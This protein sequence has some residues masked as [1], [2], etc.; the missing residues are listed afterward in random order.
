VRLGL[1]LRLGLRRGCT[2]AVQPEEC[3]GRDSHPRRP[4]GQRLYRPPQLLLCHLHVGEMAV[5][6]CCL[7][8]G[9][10]GLRQRF[11]SAFNIQHFR[12]WVEGFEPS[13]PC[14]RGTC[15]NQAELH[16]CRGSMLA[17][18]QVQNTHA[19][20]DGWDRTSDLVLPRHACFRCTTSWRLT[21]LGRHVVT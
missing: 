14:A 8:Q 9:E 18:L 15:S 3:A 12:I 13:A 2:S 1:R 20:Q 4:E 7:E 6:E 21:A 10:L 5:A 16:P 19:N 17:T 11:H